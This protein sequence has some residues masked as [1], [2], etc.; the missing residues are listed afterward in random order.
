MDVI[1][2]DTLLTITITG[3]SL[4]SD[5]AM[6]DISRLQWITID[7]GWIFKDSNKELIVDGYKTA[8]A[9][10]RIEGYTEACRYFNTFSQGIN[11]IRRK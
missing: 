4:L 10:F 8:V 5:R 1:L 6:R 2:D 7:N 11:I 9:R 3:D